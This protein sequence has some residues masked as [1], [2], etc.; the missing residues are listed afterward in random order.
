M[1]AKP[2]NRHPAIIAAL[3][4]VS[5]CAICG[6]LNPSTSAIQRDTH[7]PCTAMNPPMLIVTIGA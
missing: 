2:L 3:S 4:K 6:G 7:R 1:V 5:C